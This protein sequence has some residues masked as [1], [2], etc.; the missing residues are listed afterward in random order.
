MV[1]PSIAKFPIDDF[2][3]RFA[4]EEARQV[5]DKQTRD[6]LVALRVRAAEVRQDDDPLGRPER[7]LGG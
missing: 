5:V 3:Q 6:E 7:M 1:P 4:V 2:S